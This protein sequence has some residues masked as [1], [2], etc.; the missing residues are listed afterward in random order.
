[1]IQV[2]VVRSPEQAAAL[3]A[4]HPDV[5]SAAS[6]G[7]FI[8]VALKAGVQDFSFIPSQLLSA[9]FQINLLKEEEVN[10]ETAFMRLTKG[11]VQ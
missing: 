11:V 4:K 1:V 8:Q 7:G 6:N 3:L 5:E 9:G 10:L 2:G